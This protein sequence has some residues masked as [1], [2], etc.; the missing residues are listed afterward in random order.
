[1]IIFGYPGIGKSTLAGS[2]EARVHDVIDLESSFF[3]E[4]EGGKDPYWYR[5]Y[6]KV[7]EDL[8][9]QGITVF[10]STHEKVV[11]AL[12]KSP[13]KKIL[14]FPGSYLKSYWIKK[15]DDRRLKTGKF[16]DK[17]A[18]LRAKEHYDEDISE[19]LR[20]AR[21]ENGFE[22]YLIEN[23]NYDL[24]DILMDIWNKYRE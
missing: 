11:N 24:K 12:K 13:E 16:K 20:I 17:R 14:V 19:L 6:G 21:E 4:H 7:A 3:T 18:Y 5:L 9:R 23:M 15:L 22:M 8:S 1:M 10:V 2:K